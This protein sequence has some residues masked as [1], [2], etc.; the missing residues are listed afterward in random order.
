MKRFKLL[1]RNFQHHVLCNPL[2]EAKLAEVIELLRLPQGARILDVGCGKGEFLCRAAGRWNAAAV[3]IEISSYWVA[4]ARAN[5]A[6]RGLSD[7]VDIRQGHG[8]EYDGQ[9]GPFDV[10]ACFG[11]SFIWGGYTQT[12]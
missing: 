4:D 11:A 7:V 9:G 6:A 10:S 3:G 8:A 5:V 2:S 12:L 1:A